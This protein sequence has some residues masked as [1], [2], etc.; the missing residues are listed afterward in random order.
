MVTLVSQLQPISVLPGVQPETDATPFATRHYCMADKIRFW[1]GFPQKIGGW[2]SMSFQYGGNMAGMA[3]TFFSATINNNF[4]SVV[5]TNT[6]LYSILGQSLTNITPLNTAT[7]AIPNS[8]STDY[9]TLGSNP[10]AVVA[11]S[12]LV[13]VSDSNASHYAVNDVVVFRGAVD[14]GGIAAA[15][16]NTSHIIRSVGATSYSVMV[17]MPAT[18]TAPGGGAAVSRATGLLSIA[19]PNHGQ[20][21]GARVGLSGAGDVGGVLAATIND[22]FI[23]RNAAPSSFAVMTAGLAT[24]LVANGGGSATVYATE[25]APGL[26]DAGFGQGFGVGLYG[27]GLYGVAAVS[28]TGQTT[29]RIWFC[30]RFEER[31]LL[32]PGNQGG[33]YM[34]DG[35]IAHAPAIISTAPQDVNYLFVSNSIVV[36]VGHQ[37]IPNQIF[38]SDQ[39]DPTQ[40]VASSE[41]QVFQDVVAGAGQFISHAPVAAGNLLFTQNQTYLFSYIGLPLVWS[42]QLLD[43]AVGL[44][45][46]HARCAVHGI[47]YWMGQENFYTSSGGVVQLIPSNS[48][49][50]STLLNYVFG[51]INHAQKS[52]S[53]AWYNPLFHEIWFHYPS[54]LSNE[55]DRIARVNLIDFSWVPDTLARVCAEQ[56]VAMLGNPRLI[57]PDGTVYVHD[58]GND[59][60]G[61]PLPFT[62]TSN[63]RCGG[64][65]TTLIPGVVPDSLQTGS[66][67]LTVNGYAFPQSA[68][69]CFSNVY[70]VDPD[71]EKITTQMNARFWQYS[72]S[73]NALGQG[74]QMGQ[75]LEYTQQGADS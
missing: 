56:P 31:M 62:L 32:T 2:R 67:S 50:Q 72:W 48:S 17:G 73:G 60:D 27:A 4:C 75:W 20:A 49:G 54:A 11:G 47:A 66:I 16:L 52:K 28:A 59:A 33:V 15:S 65:A 22:E 69:P 6:K 3:R 46:P 64:K 7:T 36:T 43:N 12:N 41:N 24:A 39:G 26:L 25:I 44:I 18:S 40:W 21:N 19:A 74:W 71:T 45:A 37:N 63:L 61:V 58:Y 9:A 29:P 5:G 51:N 35:T 55:C 42:M 23:I 1:R 34:W 14:V 8:I 57:A 10:F 53:F 30:S 38:A 68:S 70:G 13:T